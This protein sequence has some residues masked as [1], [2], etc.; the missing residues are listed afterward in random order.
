MWDF[1]QEGTNNRGERTS[2]K[3]KLSYI[4]FAITFNTYLTS[5]DLQVSGSILARHFVSLD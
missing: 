4:F 3:L 1:K 5:S 2:L